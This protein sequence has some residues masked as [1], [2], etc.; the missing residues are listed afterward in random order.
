MKKDLWNPKIDSFCY[1]NHNTFSVY[2]KNYQSQFI[3]EF[4]LLH[5]Q[6]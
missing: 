2:C 4:L 6:I 5:Q 3:L 1:L